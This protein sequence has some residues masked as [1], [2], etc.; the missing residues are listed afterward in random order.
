ML[1]TKMYTYFINFLGQVEILLPLLFSSRLKWD[2]K[3]V[4][5]QLCLSLGIVHQKLGVRSLLRL[6]RRR[7]TDIHCTV[8]RSADL[9]C[10]LMPKVAS[11]RWS[12]TSNLWVPRAAGVIKLWI[13]MTFVSSLNNICDVD[14]VETTF[15]VFK[16]E[17]E[18]RWIF[19]KVIIG[20]DLLK[21]ATLRGNNQT[22][23]IFSNTR[24][25]IAM[26]K[27]CW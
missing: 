10:V 16:F 24:P 23:M 13:W 27:K 21:D 8:S 26:I 17:A 20:F 5:G 25:N 6:A 22:V 9:Y 15:N 3:V 2:I 7:I 1:R 18:S 19:K 4:V 12:V 11:N 14:V